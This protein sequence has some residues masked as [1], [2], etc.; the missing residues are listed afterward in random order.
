MNTPKEPLDHLFEHVDLEALTSQPVDA[1][2]QTVRR[3]YVVV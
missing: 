2:E 1:F 3:E